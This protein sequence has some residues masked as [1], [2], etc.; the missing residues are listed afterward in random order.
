MAVRVGHQFA[1]EEYGRLRHLVRELPEGGLLAE[2]STGSARAAG[3]TG[4]VP[5]DVLEF[6]DVLGHARLVPCV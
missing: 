5:L 4:Q 2:E 6:L 1:E 3:V